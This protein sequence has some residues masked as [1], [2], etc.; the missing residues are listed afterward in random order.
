MLL[1]RLSLQLKLTLVFAGVMALVL[2]IAGL[3]LYFR[4]KNELDASI[5]QGLRSRASDIATLVQRADLSRLKSGQSR[6]LTASERSAQILDSSGRVLAS[7]PESRARSLLGSGNLRP[8]QSHAAFFYRG[9]RARILATPV[10][11]RGRRVIV[12]VGA[13]LEDREGALESLATALLIGGPLLLL[14][15]SAAGYGVAAAALRPVESM[16]R[17]AATISAAEPGARLPL[18]RGKDEVERLARTLNEMLERLERA[19]ARE[20]AFVADASH[21]FRTPIAILK[22]ELELARDEELSVGELREAIRSA[23]EETDRLSQLAEDLLVLARSDQ[24]ALPVRPVANP[25]ADL[26]VRVADRFTLRAHES[27]RR[28]LCDGAEETSVVADPRRIEQALAN[29]VDNALRYGS[30]AIRLTSVAEDG[31]IELHVMDEGNGFSS[32]FLARAFERFSRGDEARSRGGG[33][34][35]GLSIVRAIARAHGGEA[36]AKNLPSGSADVWISLPAEP[37]GS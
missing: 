12:V 16:R 34:G 19:F 14:I 31:Q 4:L 22:A 28:I 15:A 18:P 9:E 13:S 25:V 5:D 27:G 11:V 26:F 35:L 33:A 3:F 23:A 37:R 36:H 24:D 29:L 10:Q 8:A 21:E 20:R 2:A 1:N 7:T 17:R 30:G 6:L 32:E